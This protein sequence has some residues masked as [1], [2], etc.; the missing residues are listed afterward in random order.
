MFFRL[1]MSKSQGHHRMVVGEPQ[2][3]REEFIDPQTGIA[4]AA[5]EVKQ[6]SALFTSP[7]QE[8]LLQYGVTRPSVGLFDGLCI[9][10]VIGGQVTVGQTRK[11]LLAWIDSRLLS[12]V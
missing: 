6:L 11:I 12:T 4:N 9:E 8:G 5:L 3:L 1:A 10:V 7:T 2:L